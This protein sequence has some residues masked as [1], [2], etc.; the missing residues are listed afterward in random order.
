[1]RTSELLDRVVAHCHPQRVIL[2]GSAARGE[3][4]RG[5]DI[6][7]LVVVDDDAP[8]EI[9]GARS[10]QGKTPRFLG[11]DPAANFLQAANQDSDTIVTF[12]VNPATGR[13]TPTGQVVEIGNPV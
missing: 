10:T 9:L 5:S 6:D 1:V 2:L 8:P 11:L 7:L 4:G 12:R 3:I 13:L